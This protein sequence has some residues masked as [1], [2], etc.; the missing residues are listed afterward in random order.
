MMMNHKW[1]WSLAVTALMM[2][3][4]ASAWAGDQVPYKDRV[5]AVIVGADVESGF[6]LLSF[7]VVRGQGTQ[8]GRFTTFGEL[9]VDLDT[10]EF[11]G[12]N[13]FIAANGDNIFTDILGE[14]TETDIPGVFIIELDAAFDG[15]TGRFD[16]ATGG[17]H[18]LG[19]LQLGPGGAFVGATFAGVGEGTISSPGAN[20]K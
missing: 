19:E 4:A 12:T 11:V 7:E 6:A 8:V 18:G 15:G 2:W 10:L 3:V 16:G 20:K 9:L 13:T 17:F 5:E 14:L 1:G